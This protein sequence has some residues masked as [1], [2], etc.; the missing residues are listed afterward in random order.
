MTKIKWNL[1]IL[2]GATI[3]TV[4][5]SSWAAA[6]ASPVL[7]ADYKAAGYNAVTGVWSDSSGNGNTATVGTGVTAPTLMADATPNGSSAVNF[8]ASSEWLS[9]AN[10]LAQGSGYTVLAFAEPT[11]T[12]SNYA[13][14]GGPPGAMEYRIQ[15]AG[16]NNFQ[17][18]LNTDTTAFGSSNTAVPTNAFS[19]VG[20][21]TDNL[22]AATF[23]LNGSADGTTTGNSAFTSPINLIGA[24]DTGSGASPNE[25]FVGNIAELQIYSGVLTSTQVQ[26]VDQAFI[27]SY[28][29]PVPEPATLGLLAVGGLGLLLVSRR[30]ATRQS[31]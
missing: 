5:L 29:T 20:V 6:S 19:M 23:Y 14:V 4:G 26:S 28:V 30:R 25:F 2:V 18:L 22:G 21:S 9:I 3:A 12:G 24:S 17:V 10:G 31:T 7:L 13:L 27:N 15:T 16:G 11:A 8:G 1:H